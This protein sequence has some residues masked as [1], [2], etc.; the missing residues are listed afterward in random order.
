MKPLFQDKVLQLF[1]RNTNK[2][3]YNKKLEKKSKLT[4]KF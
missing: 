3:V 1:Q 2:E 4:Q